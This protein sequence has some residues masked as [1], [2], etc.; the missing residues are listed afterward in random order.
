MSLHIHTHTAHFHQLIKKEQLSKYYHSEEKETAVL[1]GKKA[2]PLCVEYSRLSA[3][4]LNGYNP[5]GKL[6]FLTT[7]KR[8]NK[9]PISNPIGVD[10][11]ANPSL[12]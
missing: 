3:A 6:F 9:R 11:I 12:K 8:K 7:E 2:S 10:L 1:Q 5:L 4:A